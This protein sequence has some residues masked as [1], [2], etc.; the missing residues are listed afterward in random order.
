MNDDNGIFKKEVEDGKK[1]NN[2]KTD[3]NSTNNA[4]QGIGLDDVNPD[5]NNKNNKE[6]DVNT[7]IGLNKEDEDKTREEF[8][9][10][11][12][13]KKAK[14]DKKKAK[15]DKEKEDEEKYQK[16]QEKIREDKKNK[17]ENEKKQEEKQ[18]NKDAVSRFLKKTKD[19]I[20]GSSM[21]NGEKVK[22][23]DGKEKRNSESAITRNAQNADRHEKTQLG[24]LFSSLQHDNV[25]NKGADQLKARQS[26]N[27]QSEPLSL[28]RTAD[29]DQ[30]KNK[31]NAKKRNNENKQRDAR[32][33]EQNAKRT[34]KL[35]KER[36]EAEKEIA[37][38]KAREKAKRL[39]KSEESE[40]EYQN[41][42]KEIDKK[43]DKMRAEMEQRFKEEEKDMNDIAEPGKTHY[44]GSSPEEAFSKLSEDGRQEIIDTR[45]DSKEKDK[46]REASNDITAVKNLPNTLSKVNRVIDKTNN[47]KDHSQLN[48]NAQT[49]QKKRQT[50]INNN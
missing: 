1:T 6:D 46:F 28:Q 40:Q 45:L 14:E 2:N 47:I 17:K 48:I 8:E 21:I 27:K 15:E 10:E 35:E 23:Q 31:Q 5:F 19:I 30:M 7:G 20:G 49:D 34:E 4:E 18:K 38:E 26:N 16:E 36:E 12:A 29:Q 39:K 42:L 43:Y 3:D 41:D 11:Y 33:K 24:D 25:L 13:E 22:S 32:I 44:D 37:E 9:K 50:N